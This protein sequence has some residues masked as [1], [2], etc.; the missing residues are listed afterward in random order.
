MHSC[1][2]CHGATQIETLTTNRLHNRSADHIDSHT[3]THMINEFNVIFKN[4]QIHR[5]MHRGRVL[6]RGHFV[7]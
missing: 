5:D 2:D 6:K 1:S 7:D 4:A 3:H